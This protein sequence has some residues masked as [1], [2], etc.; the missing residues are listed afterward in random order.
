MKTGK[1]QTRCDLMLLLM[2]F[3]WFAYPVFFCDTSMAWSLASRRV[4][5]NSKDGQKI[6]TLSKAFEKLFEAWNKEW[7]PF[8]RQSLLLLHW[9]IFPWEQ[10]TWVAL[11]AKPR[12]FGV[13]W[14]MCRKRRRNTRHSALWR[15]AGEI[16]LEFDLFPTFELLSHS[17]GSFSC[18]DFSIWVFLGYWFPKC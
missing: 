4:I 10:K 18:F 14:R 2:Y 6:N 8:Q 1:K 17:F 11:W 13:A 5:P 12:W 16:W 15:I 9:W 7:W 3:K